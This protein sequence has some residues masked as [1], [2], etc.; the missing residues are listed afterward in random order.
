MVAAQF[1]AAVGS[2]AAA[3]AWTFDSVGNA[4]PNTITTQPTA[5]ARSTMCRSDGEF[6]FRK[7]WAVRPTPAMT[8]IARRPSTAATPPIVMRNMAASDAATPAATGPPNMPAS[9][10]GAKRRST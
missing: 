7:E 3:S 2:P 6:F 1:I 4:A 5:A 9:A 10:S 8:T